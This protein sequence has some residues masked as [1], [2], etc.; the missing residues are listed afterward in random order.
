MSSTAVNRRI[1]LAPLT[2]L[3]V[4]PDR[5]VRLAADAG[6]DFVGLRVLAV[7]A[8]E[9]SYDLSPGSPLLADT[10]TALSETGLS[11][12]DTEFLRIDADTGRDTWLPALEASQALGATRFTVAAGDEDLSRLTETLGTLVQDAAAYGVV[13]ALEPISY[14]SVR[15]L[16]A[17]AAIARDTGARVLADTLH[18]ARF[19]ASGD[20]LAD[21][22]DLVDMVQLCDSPATAPT[23]VAGLVEESRAVRLAPGDGDQDLAQYLRPLPDGLPVSV[24]VPNTDEITRRGAA[25]WIRH[26]H[27]TTTH[28]LD[29][30]TTLTGGQTS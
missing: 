22:A 15:S 8:E 25:D 26:L 18:M 12:V 20:E 30:T 10:L 1:G 24:E 27:D 29:S 13:P 17:A 19:H 9:P 2:A 4:S 7:T 14:R 28:L 11:V 23:S 16:P 21:I 6:F 5:L 3:S